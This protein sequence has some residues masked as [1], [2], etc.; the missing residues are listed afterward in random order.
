MGGEEG[1]LTSQAMHQG[2]RQEEEAQGQS[3]GGL[4]TAARGGRKEG[5]LEIG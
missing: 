3:D 1:E 2:F 5:L 4:R